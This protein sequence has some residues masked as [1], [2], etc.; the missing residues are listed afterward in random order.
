MRETYSVYK[1]DKHGKPTRRYWKLIYNAALRL[2]EVLPLDNIITLEFVGDVHPNT[3]PE[4]ARH[5]EQ[6]ERFIGNLTLNHREFSDIVFVHTTRYGRPKPIT[7]YPK[8]EDDSASEGT[9]EP[10]VTIALKGE[11]ISPREVVKEM[12]PEFVKNP[13]INP[14]VLINRLKN[15]AEEDA[16]K[17]LE[18][19][20]SWKDQAVAERQRVA[21]LEE[22]KKQLEDEKKQ[23]EEEVKRL[24]EEKARASATDEEVI[25]DLAKVLESVETDVMLGG[26]A[27][28]VLTFEDGSTKIMKVVTWDKDLAVTRKAKSLVGRRVTTTCWDP[29]SEPGRWSKN[30][31]FRNIYEV[32]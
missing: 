1:T 9:V 12:H 21:N 18:Y 23:L 22:E 7:F 20:E 5:D 28:T 6:N 14:V 11:A 17:L 8:S 16:N 10:L 13:G 27:N 31:Y 3:E 24:E 4:K 15:I 29:V 30:G 32:E 19:A 2:G 25:A 26:N